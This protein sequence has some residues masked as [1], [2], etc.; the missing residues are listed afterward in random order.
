MV[1]RGFSVFLDVI[2]LHRNQT[3]PLVVLWEVFL[4]VVIKSPCATGNG[5]NSAGK[6]TIEVPQD[7]SVSIGCSAQYMHP[8]LD[9]FESASYKRVHK[10][11]LFGG[12]PT[13]LGSSVGRAGD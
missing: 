3:V 8:V 2:K 11:Q 1:V 10:V 13:C 6:T 12:V 9:G 4:L 5:S 7:E